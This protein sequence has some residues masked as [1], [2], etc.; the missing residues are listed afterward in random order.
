[1]QPFATS[2]TEYPG[3]DLDHLFAHDEEVDEPNRRGKHKS[4]DGCR[5]QGNQP[6][7]GKVVEYGKPGVA[8]GASYADYH[9]N[10]ERA[11][12]IGEREEYEHAVEVRERLGR[13]IE[14]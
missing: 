11:E 7:E 9:G 6:H 13:N 4:C 5:G 8:A 10:I 14:K 3:D 2:Q 12:R 1:M